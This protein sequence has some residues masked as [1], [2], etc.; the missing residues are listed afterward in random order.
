MLIFLLAWSLA[1]AEVESVLAHTLIWL[2][3]K[4]L[5]YAFGGFCLE[6]LYFKLKFH[7]QHPPY[8]ARTIGGEHLL[9]VYHCTVAQETTVAEHSVVRFFLCNFYNKGGINP[10]KA[11]NKVIVVDIERFV[12]L[13]DFR[14]RRYT[15]VKHN[16]E[17]Q[18]LI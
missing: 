16:L 15:K 14:R 1:F 9:K 11:G 13:V 2:S 12:L 4:Y 18:V 8:C 5:D 7:L 3:C 10:A 17:K 6:R